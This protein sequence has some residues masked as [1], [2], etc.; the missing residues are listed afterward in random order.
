ML[1]LKAK[2]VDIG[3]QTIEATD[4][5]QVFHVYIPKTTPLRVPEEGEFLV[6]KNEGRQLVLQGVVGTEGEIKIPGAWNLSC[7]TANVLINGRQ[8]WIP[9][10]PGWSF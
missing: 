2:S 10:S 9:T 7:K 8:A 1:L 3:M 6:A 5:R 4:G